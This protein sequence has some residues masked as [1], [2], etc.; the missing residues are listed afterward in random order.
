MEFMPIELW[1][2]I[3][4]GLGS[5]VFGAFALLKLR[6]KAGAAIGLLLAVCIPLVV[7]V[8]AP[9]SSATQQMS[10]V[11]FQFLADLSASKGDWPAMLRAQS[12]SIAGVPLF[13]QTIARAQPLTRFVIS[14]A[15]EGSVLVIGLV[16]A[17]EGEAKLGLRCFS[18]DFLLQKGYAAVRV[19][20]SVGASPACD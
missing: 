15:E 8:I 9:S 18:P 11:K 12:S 1:F 17:I 2:A 19:S 16:S 5:A 7:A 20:P 3:A 4:A 6:S 10:R 14:E 13:A